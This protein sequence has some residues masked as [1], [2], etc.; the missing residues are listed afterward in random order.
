MQMPDLVKSRGLDFNIRRHFFGDRY[1]KDDKDALQ[2]NKTLVKEYVNSLPPGTWNEFFLWPAD[3]V[4]G[5]YDSVEDWSVPEVILKFTNDMSM[6]IKE[7]KP[8]ARMSFLSYWST[9]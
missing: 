6:A 7:I 3:V 5:L 4:L 2:K 8:E 1:S 9:W